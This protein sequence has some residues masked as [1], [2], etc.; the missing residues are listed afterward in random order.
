MGCL[1]KFS[2]VPGRAKSRQFKVNPCAGA[3][4]RAEPPEAGPALLGG[5]P[6]VARPPAGGGAQRGP[7]HHRGRGGVRVPGAE[8][9]LCE[10]TLTALLVVA[11]QCS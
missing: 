10:V 3:I 11:L 2:V 9:L 8:W 1:L 4:W 5:G 6:E 7:G